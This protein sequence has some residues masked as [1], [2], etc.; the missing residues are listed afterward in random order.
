VA[1]GKSGGNAARANQPRLK[2]GEDSLPRLQIPAPIDELLSST[3]SIESTSKAA[4]SRSLCSPG[5]LYRRDAWAAFNLGV[6]CAR[7]NSLFGRRD[8]IT[9]DIHRLP[10]RKSSAGSDLVPGPVALADEAGSSPFVIAAL[11]RSLKTRWK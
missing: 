7:F 5:L 11:L 9:L 1:S 3:P 4:A 2:R 6:V 10:Q 8:R